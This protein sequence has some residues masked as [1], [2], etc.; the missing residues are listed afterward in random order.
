MYWQNRYLKEGAVFEALTGL[1][2]I[3]LPNKGL[4][5][6]IE[7][8]VWGTCGDNTA[9]PDVWLHDRLQKIELIVNGSQVVK[10]LTGEQLLADMLYK[11]TPH[12][13]HDM[14][15]ISAAS[16]EE[17]FYINLGRHYHDMDYML[18]LGKVNDPEIRITNSFALTGAHGW[19]EGVAMDLKPSYSIV[20]HILREPPA[21]P[22]GYIKTSELYRFTGA[23]A[24]KENMTVPRG[25]MYSNLYVQSW[26]AAQGISHILDKLEL[27]IN[28]DDIIPFRVG[29]AELAAEIARQYGLF[30]IDQQCYLKGKQAYPAPM[31]VGRPDGIEDWAVLDVALFR[32]DLW[33]NNWHVPF[34]TVT[35]G[36]PSE[37]V[38]NTRMLY[39]GVMPF[40]VATIPYF[41]PWD[42]RTRIDS[43]KL[44]DLWVRFEG[45]TNMSTSVVV[46]LLGDEVVTKYVA[47]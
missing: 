13:S 44:G 7:L 46:K 16:C 33:A 25:P 28:S 15:N 37:D 38:V 3:D 22:K 14:K 35:T 9:K 17:F 12:Y 31:E 24:K 26:Y 34:K 21:A 47:I 30:E 1:E 4:L 36:A 5:S 20:L 8:K 11:K 19:D 41:D 45:N 40:S 23:S 2:T 6:G 10:S 29:P 18:D 27:N 42:E 43:S 32:S 39:R